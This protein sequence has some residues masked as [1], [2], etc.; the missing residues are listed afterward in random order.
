MR[1]FFYKFTFSED[2]TECSGFITYDV[3]TGNLLYLKDTSQNGR[4]K[5]YPLFSFKKVVNKEVPK[6]FPYLGKAILERIET[7]EGITFTP[8]YYK[9]KPSHTVYIKQIQFRKNELYPSSIAFYFPFEDNPITKLSATILV[10]E[11]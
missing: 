9:G 3:L 8:K 5:L 1:N 2:S 11:N 7:K 4:K 6:L 10:I